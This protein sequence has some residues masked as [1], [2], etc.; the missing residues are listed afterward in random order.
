MILSHCITSVAL[1]VVVKLVTCAALLNYM[2]MG[3]VIL[4]FTLIIWF[5]YR[6]QNV[7]HLKV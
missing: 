3:L 5:K 2:V 7:I 6:H 4:R 1:H